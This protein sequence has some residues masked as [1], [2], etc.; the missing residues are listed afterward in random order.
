VTAVGLGLGPW[1]P[2]LPPQASS[3]AS[4][5]TAIQPRAGRLKYELIFS[6]FE[7]VMVFSS[8]IYY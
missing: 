4:A 3:K 1:G 6:T 5:G 7:M 2:E 8:V